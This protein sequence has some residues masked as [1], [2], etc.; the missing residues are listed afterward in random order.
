MNM[1]NAQAFCVY[2]TLEVI[3][4]CKYKYF[5]LGVFHV[6]SLSFEYFNNGQKFTIVHFILYFSGNQLLREKSY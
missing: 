2:E 6:V 1:L 5:M 3:I 4:I